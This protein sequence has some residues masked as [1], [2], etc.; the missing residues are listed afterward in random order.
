MN[1]TNDSVKVNVS[2]PPVFLDVAPSVRADAEDA[3]IV[4]DRPEV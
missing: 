3:R 1:D 2:G 4:D